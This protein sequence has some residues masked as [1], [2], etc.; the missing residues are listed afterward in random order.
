VWG[1]FGWNVL[2]EW[3]KCRPCNDKTHVSTTI[4]RGKT[5]LRL[6]LC[7]YYGWDKSFGPKSLAFFI[8]ELGIFGP[9]TSDD[10]WGTLQFQYYQIYTTFISKVK[11]YI[12]VI[13]K[14]ISHM[15][16][17]DGVPRQ[18]DSSFGSFYL[19]CDHQILSKSFDM[20]GVT[21]LMVSFVIGN[22]MAD[23]GTAVL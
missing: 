22:D 1:L 10:L 5:L 2:P 11:D 7:H 14:C 23:T 15:I 17:A 16:C 20:D 12:C 13:R 3:I 19:C 6:L 4:R 18:F 9:R 21:D 8:F